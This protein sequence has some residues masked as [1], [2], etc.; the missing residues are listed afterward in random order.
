MGTPFLRGDNMEGYSK[1]TTFHLPGI[2]EMGIVW[3]PFMELLEQDDS[4]LKTNAKFG[5]IYGSPTCIWNGGRN[6]VGMAA[7][8]KNQLYNIREF[9]EYHRIPL[10][11]T[12]TN[13][14]LTE[15]HLKDTYCNLVTDIFAT[16]NNEIICNSPILEN[17]LRE[18]YGNKYRYISSTTKT[19]V[20]KDRQI[21]EIN[22]DYF[23]TVLDLS[24]NKDFDF[25]NSIE[26]KD[27]CEL[28]CNSTC[29]ANCPN[30]TKHY[31]LVSR[32][33]LEHTGFNDYSECDGGICSYANAQTRDHYISPED[34]EKIY[35]PM[36][37][38]NFKLEGR[39]AHPLILVDIL[40]DYLIKDS[41]K[42]K[43]KEHLYRKLWRHE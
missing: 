32:N 39:N 17:Y 28:L 20:D 16:G 7:F 8:T 35:L 2:F 36:G 15:D 18:R 40:V 23:L 6:T 11:F 24:H 41:C 22:K 5:S 13:C 29:Y 3:Q 4:V 1:E 9:M 30:K 27:K 14:L 38:S 34:I 21:E 37:F 12:F 25:L 33:Q 26:H 43:V 31:E 10:R 19:I 42:N